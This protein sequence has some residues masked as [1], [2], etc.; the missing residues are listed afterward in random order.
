M[1]T[2]TKLAGLLVLGSTI[3]PSCVRA[4]AQ[5]EVLPADDSAAPTK[6]QAGHRSESK[7][8]GG[9]SSPFIMGVWKFIP[10]SFDDSPLVDSEFRFLNPTDLTLTIE[11]AFYELDDTFCGCDRDTFVPGPGGKSTVVYTLLGESR[12]PTGNVDIPNAFSC[13]GLSG[14]VK[15]IVFLPDGTKLNFD[16]AQQVGFQTHVHG[17]V[18]ELG[19]TS[20][21]GAP[22][23]NF[24]FLQGAVMTEAGMKGIFF[25]EA[26]EDEA[27]KV[28][29][30]CV[31]ILGDP[32]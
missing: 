1:R 3:E 21:M 15:S 2:F 20:V 17:Q 22:I 7:P 8:K 6:P 12:T 10:S 25:N 4:G 24:T 5:E 11:Y 30:Q 23:N 16:G 27:Q 28:H 9:E 32:K 29:Q 13:S 31:S 26:A 19:G 14:A 18:Q